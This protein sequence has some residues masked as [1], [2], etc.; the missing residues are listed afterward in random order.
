[1]PPIKLDTADLKRRLPA[2]V[3][4]KAFFGMHAKEGGIPVDQAAKLLGFDS[5]DALLTSVTGLRNRRQM[6]EAE[7]DVRM[8]SRFG[9]MLTDGTI[10]E[11]AMAALHNEKKADVH[12]AE[13][14][15]L[16]TRVG[17]K[18]APIEVLRAAA[19]RKINSL[20]IKDILPQIYARAEA[21]ARRVLEKALAKQDFDAAWKAK[22]QE[23]LNHELYRAAIDAK[24]EAEAIV[25]RAKK[26]TEQK[27]RDRI[28]KAGGWEWTVTAPDGRTATFT[29]EAEAKAASDRVSGSTYA[30]TSGYLEKIDALLGQYEFRRVSDKALAR[31]ETLREWAAKR[32]A[33]GLPVPIPDAV[34]D[35]AGQRN[36]KTVPLSEL[37]AV[38]DTLVLIATLAKNKNK[39]LATEREE[40]L[41]GAAARLAAILRRTHP[42]ENQPDAGA[43]PGNVP[44]FIAAHRK[45]ANIAR[46]M[47]GDEDA[48]DFWD[49]LIRPMNEAAD[50][51]AVR[52]REAKQ[53]QEA[54]WKAWSKAT[55]NDGWPPG[56]RRE[57]DGFKGGL[58]RMSAILVALNWG[59]EGNRQ[60]LLEGGQGRGPLT[61]PQVQAV[62]DSLNA[63]DWDLVEGVWDHI[64]SYWSDIAALE[65][66]MTGTA[67]EKVDASPFPTKHGT[68]KGGYFP[69]MYDG[70]ETGRIDGDS[71]DLAK[72]IQAQAYGTTTTSRGHTKERTIGQGRRLNLDPGVIGSHLTRVI[73]DL[74]HRAALSDVMR[75]LMHD[76]VRTAIDRRMGSATTRTL[77]QWIADI[78]TGGQPPDAVARAIG[79]LRKGF[80]ISTMGFRAMTAAIQLT[81]FS[82]SA[83]R[84]GPARM[85]KAFATLFSTRDG[86]AAYNF[87]ASKSS[88]MRERFS[89]MTREMNETIGQFQRG[90]IDNFQAAV[91]AKAFWMMGKV[92]GVVDRA[93][94]LAAYEKAIDEGNEAD[95][96]A[97]ANQTVIDTQSGGQT[98]DLSG[99]ARSPYG[100]ILTGAYTY[101][102]LVFNQLYDQG[103]RIKRNPKDF[104]T[105]AGAFGNMMLAAALPAA[106]SVALRALLRNDWPDDED[107]DGIGRRY[108]NEMASTILGTMVGFRELGG[109]FSGFDYSGPGVT[110]PFADM[111]RLG[112]QAMQGEFDVG[113]ARAIIDTLGSS[114]GLP[115]GQAWATG[116]GLWELIENPDADLRAPIFGPPP[117]R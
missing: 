32:E 68:I 65:Q 27:T 45:A 90:K 75:V 21:K 102:S 20:P 37:R 30:R 38:N 14:K 4:T 43:K 113:L 86:M 49:A 88:M 87:P 29:T 66:R 59:N 78:A 105:W 76:D 74:T 100:Q 117:R 114:I 34:L 111:T 44:G 5:A 84:V 67:P 60:R 33:E 13:V 35:A 70:Q 82:N 22:Q 39:L 57:F 48:G 52:L 101:G 72:Q 6:I 23:M 63:A 47:D 54:L 103:A 12:L 53:R 116:A 96:V 91:G 18:A 28:G 112:N 95:A 25:E 11:K 64:D 62:L 92:Q 24:R 9:D 16:A 19:Q 50:A 108:A 85:A 71:T 36:Y 77:R 40:Q 104:G 94:W 17:K 15:A 26:Y 89:T 80:S 81:G 58:T 42:T 41:D 51:E 10:A 107:K 55:A 115:S 3:S 7:T 46:E 106:L 31:R 56:E 8:R 1:M 93:T 83:V 97:I 109:M 73:H 99:V 98:K 2:G 110:K 61:D 79:Q 69:I